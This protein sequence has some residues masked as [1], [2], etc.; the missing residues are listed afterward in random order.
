[1]DNLMILLSTVGVL[2]VVLAILVTVIGN[3]QDRQAKHARAHSAQH[4]RT[5]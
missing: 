1:M 2:G 3:R 4:D 5:R